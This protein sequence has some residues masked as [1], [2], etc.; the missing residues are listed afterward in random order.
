MNI[1]KKLKG[2]NLS[3]KQKETIAGIVNN[4]ENTNKKI[5]KFVVYEDDNTTAVYLKKDDSDELIPLVKNDYGFI[6]DDEYYKTNYDKYEAVAEHTR[7]FIEEDDKIVIVT[8]IIPG[9]KAQFIKLTDGGINK[10]ID[11]IGYTF[12]YGDVMFNV[13]MNNNN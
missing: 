11:Y 10:A 13:F 9:L 12:Y 3:L 5:I 1:I 2:F 6:L 7:K 4:S 8:V